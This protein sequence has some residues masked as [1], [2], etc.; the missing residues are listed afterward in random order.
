MSTTASYQLNN[1][2]RS[3]KEELDRFRF[4]Q[5]ATEKDELHFLLFDYATITYH[6]RVIQKNKQ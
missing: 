3:L 2:V 1:D 6:L 4:A 5:K